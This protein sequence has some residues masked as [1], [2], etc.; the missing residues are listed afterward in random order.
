[1][2]SGPVIKG[3]GLILKAAELEEI[4]ASSFVAQKV[5]RI[6]GGASGA[7]GFAMTAQYAISACRA[8][9]G[10]LTDSK[11]SCDSHTNAK[12]LSSFET[13]ELD[14]DNCGLMLVSTVLTETGVTQIG[15]RL[16]SIFE[17]NPQLMANIQ[18]VKEKSVR[19]LMIKDREQTLQYNASD[20]SDAKDAA[21]LVV[22]PKDDVDDIE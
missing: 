5:G 14:A 16:L 20:A 10:H 15:K 22:P 19:V 11:T 18:S 9:A 17:S 7:Y 4:F 21:E 6:F 12:D 1:M 13:R 2:L 8:S 3:V